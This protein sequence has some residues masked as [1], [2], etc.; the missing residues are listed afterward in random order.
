MP[1]VLTPGKKGNTVCT[2]YIVHTGS[3]VLKLQMPVPIDTR[4]R[5]IFVDMIPHY[6]VVKVVVIHLSSL[7]S[8]LSSLSPGVPLSAA[9]RAA[10]RAATIHP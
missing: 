4:T 5:F 3:Y 1:T 8:H 6:C 7:I 9:T 2:Q 10:T